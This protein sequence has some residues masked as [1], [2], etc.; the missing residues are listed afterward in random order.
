M[1]DFWVVTEDSYTDE[2]T[3]E[4]AIRTARHLLEHEGFAFAAVISGTDEDE[5]TVLY[6]VYR[7]GK[8]GKLVATR[9]RARAAKLR[10]KFVARYFG[11]G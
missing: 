1:S 6:F 4:S 7:V 8:R 10:A 9:D 11:R 2:D 5:P 3:L